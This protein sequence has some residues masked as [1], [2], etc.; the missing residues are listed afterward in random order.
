MMS[1]GGICGGVEMGCVWMEFENVVD[2]VRRA[3]RDE[4]WWEMF[5][6]SFLNNF[7]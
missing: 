4:V 6:A 2:V 1:F 3:P 5:K 7:F